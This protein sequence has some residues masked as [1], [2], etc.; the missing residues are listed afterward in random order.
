MIVS[1]GKIEFKNIYF[2][3]NP[4]KMILRNFSLKIFMGEKI[5]IVGKTGCGKSTIGRLLVRF[6]DPYKGEINIDGQ[7]IQD[8]TQSSLHNNIGIIPQD[9]VLFNDTILYNVQY[10]NQ[11]ASFDQISSAVKEACIDDFITSLPDGYNTIV[12]ERGLKLSG[13]EK[14]RIGIARTILKGAPI[15]LLDEATSSLDYTT[16]KKLLSN[17]KRIKN[18]ATMIIIS[19]RL[20]AIKDVDR[21]IVLNSGEIIEEGN[22]FDLIKAKGE[23]YNLWKNQ[24]V[25]VE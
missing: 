10:A 13:G 14:Q 21:I 5:A 11:S 18:H 3:Y 19:H 2:F 22:H 16:E 24:E 23:Y 6:Y 20:S 17:L 8:V 1:K 7:S 4:E 15:L 25:E 12:G 9:T